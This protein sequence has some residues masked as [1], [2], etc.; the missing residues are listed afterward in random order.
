MTYHK[1]KVKYAK[2]AEKLECKD[3]SVIRLRTPKE[4]Q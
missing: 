4:S 2:L 1:N 3:V